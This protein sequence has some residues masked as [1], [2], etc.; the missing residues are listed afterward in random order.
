MG[1]MI[2]AMDGNQGEKKREKVRMWIH[3]A[4]GTF[5]VHALAITYAR[6]SAS[7][8]LRSSGELKELERGMAVNVGKDLDWLND[9]LKD[10][11][12][13]VGERV[14][15]ADTMVLFS[16]SL[17]LRGIWWRGGGLGSGGMWRGGLGSVRLRRVGRGL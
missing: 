15:A 4:E 7:E 3:A 11:R 6:W 9:E 5:M 17:F 2:S 1:G 13:L 8:G 16:I 10:S 12:F 14:T